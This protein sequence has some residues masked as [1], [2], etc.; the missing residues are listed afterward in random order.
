MGINPNQQQKQMTPEQVAMF[1]EQQRRVQE[2]M[3][4]F[5]I[6]DLNHPGNQ[7]SQKILGENTAYRIS[8]TTGN[9]R[10]YPNVINI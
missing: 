2:L 6:A 1:Q 3:K 5:N 9:S 10:L 4:A 8:I 7:Q